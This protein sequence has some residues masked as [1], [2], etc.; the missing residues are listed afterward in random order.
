M[1]ILQSLFNKR[2]NV[3]Q[4]K[5]NDFFRFFFKIILDKR[6]KIAYNQIANNIKQPRKRR[7]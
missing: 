6:I 2:I 7:K 3:T 4:A 5:E 1:D